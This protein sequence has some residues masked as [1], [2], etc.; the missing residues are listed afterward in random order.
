MGKSDLRDADWSSVSGAVSFASSDILIDYEPDSKDDKAKP[1][2]VGDGA[3]CWAESDGTFQG[4]TQ[5]HQDLPAGLYRAEYQNNRGA[6]LQRLDVQLD[7]LIDLPD[8]PTAQ[9]IQEID[10][11]WDLRGRFDERGFL[12]KRGIVMWGDP[13]GGKTSC[14]QQIA[15]RIIQRGGI[16]MMVQNPKIAVMNL[17][18]LRRIE[19][20]RE[21]V[22][23][24]EDI[25]ALIRQHEE[26]GFLSL[27]D[28]ENQIAHVVYIATTNYPE[29]LDKRIIDRPSRFDMVVRIP[30]PSEADRRRFLQAKE[31]SLTEE[32][33]TEWVRLSKGFSIAHLKEMIIA[34]RVFDQPVTEVVSRLEKMMER[35]TSSDDA[36]ETKGKIGFR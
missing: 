29:K 15:A 9:V 27:L 2:P 16:A 12:H 1:E 19:P 18:M 34:V 24:M 11:F 7:D 10:R 31:P 20:D 13:G 5:T 8:S 3:R 25:D 32:D 26:E 17:E 14:I 6:F 21:V 23:F 4:I 22:V 35:K 28:G 33:L 30:M 36:R